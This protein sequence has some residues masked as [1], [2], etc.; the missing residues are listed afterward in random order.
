L[1]LVVH[2]LNNLKK[3]EIFLRFSYFEFRAKFPFDSQLTIHVNNSNMLGSSEIGRTEIDLEDRFYSKC[4]AT[5]GLPLN[6]ERTGY[7]SWRDYNKPS[8]ILSR[9]CKIYGFSPPEYNENGVLTLQRYGDK[10]KHVYPKNMNNINKKSDILSVTIDQKTD[11]KK[12]KLKDFEI[13][14]KNSLEALNDWK[15]ITG[16]K[17][18]K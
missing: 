14:E 11:A 5:C 12:K 17:Q 3:F 9:M 4:Y 6:Y 10:D 13:R 16:V 8:Q 2:R 1:S 18:F 15:H 7:N